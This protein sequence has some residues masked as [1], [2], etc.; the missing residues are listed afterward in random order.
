MNK[1]TWGQEVPAYGYRV[2]EVELRERNRGRRA[3]L[4]EE[5]VPD[6]PH[7]LDVLSLLT[8]DHLL[9]EVVVCVPNLD[10]P[11]EDPDEAEQGDPVMLVSSMEQK[12][13]RLSLSAKYGFKGEFDSGVREHGGE[14][15]LRELAAAKAFRA[16]L[17]APKTGIKGYLVVESISGRCPVAMIVNWWGR[18]AY[19]N[20]PF[21][22]VK[23]NPAIDEDRIREILSD[24]ERVEIELSSR[25]RTRDGGRQAKRTKL[26]HEVTTQGGRADLFGMAVEAATSRQRFD[27]SVVERIAGFEPELLEAANLRFERAAIAVSKSDGT[28]RKILKPDKL[29]EIFTYPLSNEIRPSDAVWEREILTRVRRLSADQGTLWA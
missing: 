17:F 19:E 13:G 14:I 3:L 11:G 2:F 24:S 4:W 22:K 7:H 1:S 20:G 5:P 10:H 6:E 21:I 29:R 18:L 25:A 12:A 23:A 15:N 26:V 28:G 8:H 16:E 27:V 9:D